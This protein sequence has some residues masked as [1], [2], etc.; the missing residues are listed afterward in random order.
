VS[1]TVL[2][3]MTLKNTREKAE[4]VCESEDYNDITSGSG[5]KSWKL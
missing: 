5:L 4:F 3:D 2:P 1:E